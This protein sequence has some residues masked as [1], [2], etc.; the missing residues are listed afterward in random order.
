MRVD[1]GFAERL[2]GFD[3][4]ELDRR[5]R[6]QSSPSPATIGLAYVNDAWDQFAHEGGARWATGAWDL[7]ASVL[8]ATAEILRPF[9]RRLY[10]EARLGAP[11]DHEYDCSRPDEVRRLRMRVHSS[12]IRDGWLVV[13]SDVVVGIEPTGVG[14]ADESL[15]RAPD[16]QT[17]AVLPLPTDPTGPHR[18][19]GLKPPSGSPAFRADTTHD[20]CKVCFAYHYGRRHIA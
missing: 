10:A 1:P 8:D 13:N 17:R 19:V 3:L 18:R 6:T 14:A 5:A 16:G 4:A 15:F 11:I 12:S 7:G 20:L 2:T 9:D